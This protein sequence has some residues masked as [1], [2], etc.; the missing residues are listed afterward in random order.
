MTTCSHTTIVLLP[1]K[2]N[3]LRCLHCHLAIRAEE[4]GDS[5]CPECY[6]ADGNKRYDF[7]KIEVKE[8]ETDRYRCE[9][10]GAII[11]SE[12]Q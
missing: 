2:K 3:I 7:E 12:K 6:E 11:E 4:L 5:Y 9:D 8:A 1:E 10:C